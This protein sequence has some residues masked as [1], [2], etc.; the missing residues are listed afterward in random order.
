MKIKYDVKNDPF[1][2][3]LW[4][5]TLNVLQVIDDDMVILDTLLTM[6]ESRNSAHISGIQFQDKV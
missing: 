1:P 6:P 3:C 5:G 2:P 4:S